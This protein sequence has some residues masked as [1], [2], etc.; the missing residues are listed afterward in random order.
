MG[1]RR[2]GRPLLRV[3]LR[4]QPVTLASLAATADLEVKDVASLVSVLI[5]GQAA[6]VVGT[7]L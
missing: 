3:L 2:S 6:A 1:L 5:E 7:A 4:G